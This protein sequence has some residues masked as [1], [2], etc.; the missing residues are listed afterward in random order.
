MQDNPLVSII[1]LCYNHEL[2]VI[3]ALESVIVQSYKNIELIIVNDC[4]T[5]NSKKIIENWLKNHPEVLFLSNDNNIGNTKSFN[6]ALKLARGEFIIDLASDDVLLRNCIELQIK[7]FEKSSYK[8]LGI[9]YGNAELISESGRFESYYFEVNE[10]KKLLKKR[11]TSNIYVDIL[12]GGK[13]ICSVSAMVKKEVY[14]QLNGYDENLYYE[15]LDFWIRTARSYEF[16]FID[17]ILIQKR[18]VDN[19]LG[20]HFYKKN[21][22]R[23][24]KINY[25]T[26]LIIKKAIKLNKNKTE[27]KALIKRIHFD[28]VLN[29]KNQNYLLMFKYFYLKIKLFFR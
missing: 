15:D 4:S 28:I 13:S 14:D 18:T 25:A 22:D 10:Q 12:S 29:F 2:F 1:C 7:G 9:V 23:A 5:D 26:Y 24:K 8:N 17:E 20:T 21:D 3:E 27:D 16:D 11:P 19:S 6:K